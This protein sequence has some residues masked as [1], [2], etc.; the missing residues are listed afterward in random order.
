MTLSIPESGK[1]Q[2]QQPLDIYIYLGL[3]LRADTSSFKPSP[4]VESKS[5]VGMPTMGNSHSQLLSAPRVELSGP[6]FLPPRLEQ[7]LLLQVGDL[8]GFF[9]A[10]GLRGLAAP[11][12]GHP[13][14][15]ASRAPSWYRPSS[16][17]CHY[18]YV[19]ATQVMTFFFFPSFSYPRNFR[20]PGYFLFFFPLRIDVSGAHDERL[21]ERSERCPIRQLLT[22]A[23]RIFCPGPGSPSTA[24]AAVSSWPLFRTPSHPS[25]TCLHSA[26]LL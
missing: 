8:P 6:A 12:L 4:R 2:Q 3:L 13:D 9:L 5:Q 24:P 21:Y 11:V 10:S 18:E 7:S 23:I 19:S 15:S 26:V 17:I 20:V 1:H 14:R 16:E 25:V 22:R